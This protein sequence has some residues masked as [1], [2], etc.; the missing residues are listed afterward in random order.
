MRR[1]AR[2]IIKS[3]FHYEV[4]HADW[5]CNGLA[6]YFVLHGTTRPG[7]DIHAQK[8]KLTDETIDSPRPITANVTRNETSEPPASQEKTK[9]QATHGPL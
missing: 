8:G 7:R 4:L 5:H 1:P 6:K 3:N 2:L 9:L